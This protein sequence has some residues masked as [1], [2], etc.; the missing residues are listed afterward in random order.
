MN[1]RRHH[2]QAGFSL[3]EVMIAI[4]VLGIGIAGLTLGITTA[5]TSSK[6]AERQTA[7]ALL[8]AGRI[9][10]LR[11]EGYVV[12]GE[13]EGTGEDDLAK[14]QWRQT[15]SPTSIDGLFDVKVKVTWASSGDLIYE[16]QTLLFD[17]PVY[18]TL[19]DTDEQQK[20]QKQRP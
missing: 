3:I 15:V 9:E 7:A 1:G 19:D 8:A 13:D 6:E 11:A 17:P 10:T 18:S 5:L 2:P 14:Y 4:L 20:R 12:E 16:L